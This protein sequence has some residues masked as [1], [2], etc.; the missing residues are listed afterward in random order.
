MTTAA[1]GGSHETQSD[2][3][4]LRWLANKDEINELSACEREPSPVM[5]LKR[6]FDCTAYWLY[7]GSIRR[8]SA[9]VQRRTRKQI[10]G[11]KRNGPRYYVQHKRE[12][13][14]F[15]KLSRGSLWQEAPRSSLSYFT[16]N[17]RLRLICGVE[18]LT[19]RQKGVGTKQTEIL[20]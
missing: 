18:R 12:K 16:I 7:R 5:L 3:N 2:K 6:C 14:A 10:R 11:Q 15:E 8:A 13:T 9:K 19:A 17:S 4:V 20:C 1:K